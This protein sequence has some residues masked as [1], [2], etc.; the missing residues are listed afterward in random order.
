MINIIISLFLYYVLGLSSTTVYCTVTHVIDGDT[1]V[2][3]RNGV[4]GEII[5]LND[6]DA[7]EIKQD[8][9]PEAKNDL[10][11]ILSNKQ[12][13]ISP[14]GSDKYHRTLGTLYAIDENGIAEIVNQ[15]MVANGSAWAYNKTYRKEQQTAKDSKL[16][17]WYNP[18][19]INPKDFRKQ[20]HKLSGYTKAGYILFNF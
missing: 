3:S 5:R 10:I 17:L 9:G 7:P 18:D 20:E 6:I 15:K 16:G 8:Y 13:F 1:V 14:K 12:I 2:I 19:A 11:N 4:G